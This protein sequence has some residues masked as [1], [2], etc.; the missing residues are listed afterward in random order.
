[1]MHEKFLT[2]SQETCARL[3]EVVA[4]APATPQQPQRRHVQYRQQDPLGPGAVDRKGS[5]EL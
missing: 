1:M 5:Q 4:R 3:P 2:L